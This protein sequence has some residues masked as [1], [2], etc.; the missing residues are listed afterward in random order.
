MEYT[1]IKMKNFN[2][3]V[4]KNDNFKTIKVKVNF[5]RLQKKEEV[6]KRIMLINTLAESTKNYPTQRDLEIETENL[7]NLSF[8]VQAINSG[9]Y[10]LVS[11]VTKF[12][13]EKYTEDT[14]FEKS[15]E[16][17][18]EIIFNPNIK[19]NK[20][21]QKSFNFAKRYIEDEIDSVKDNPLNYSIYKA[22]EAVNNTNPALFNHVGYKEDLAKINNENL[23]EYYYDVINNDIVD[24][25][26]IG[27]IDI[28]KT[29]E[30]FEEK[31]VFNDRNIISETHFSLEENIGKEEIIEENLPVNQGKL[32]MCYNFD[33]LTDFENRY[34]SIIYSYILGNSSD[35]KLFVNIREKK[36]LCYEINSIY[37]SLSGLLTV[38]SGVNFD[39]IN[40]VKEL[41]EKEIEA[42]KSGDFTIEDIKNG[43]K[44]YTNGCIKIFDSPSSIINMYCAHEYMNSA[45]TEE[46]IENINK[47]SKE[48]IM[49]FANKI[50]LNKIFELRGDL[51]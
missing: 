18:R 6:T 36:S 19:D 14:M 16:F 50:H 35:S 13:N 9:R 29:K 3:H 45:L 20:F 33:K 5:K 34:V 47:V 10:G 17:L 22:Y 43:I 11:I 51:K 30:I 2:L 44:K 23:L 4:I 41:I 42:M 32:V 15:I 1:K 7:Y 8:Y 12:L 46:K 27:N 37:N 24:I 21:D 28:K 49:N 48:D 26:I 38:Y 31:F 40:L 39:K 25:F